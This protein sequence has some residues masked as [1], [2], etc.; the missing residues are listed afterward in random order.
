MARIQQATVW[1]GIGRKGAGAIPVSGLY[2]ILAA[3]ACSPGAGQGTDVGLEPDGGAEE[4]GVEDVRVEPGDVDRDVTEEAVSIPEG[5]NPAA[6]EHDCLMP[7]PSNV[8]LIFDERLP[9]GKRV[10]IGEAGLP[11]TKGNRAINPLSQ[12]TLDGFSHHMP[13]MAQFHQ[14][15]DTS[16]LVFHDQDPGPSLLA[17]HGTIILEVGAGPVAHWAEIDH[18]RPQNPSDR[19]LYLRP[20]D[21]LKNGTR[22]IVALQGL[23]TVDGEPV[24]TPEGFRQIRDGIKGAHPRLDEEIERYEAEIFP[25]LEA[26]GLERANLLL[27]W[28]FTTGTM[29]QIAADLLGMREKTLAY[30]A[31]QRAE[32]TVTAIDEDVNAQIARRVRG[33]MTVPLFMEHPDV[34]ALIFRNEEGQVAQN[35]TVEV[36]FTVVIPRSVMEM[37]PAQRPVRMI[38]YGHGFFGR[39]VEVEQSYMRF[40]TDAVGVVAMAVDWA[41]MSQD[42][43]VK[44]AEYLAQQPEKALRFID[45]VHQGVINQ[46]ALTEAARTTLTELDAL[47]VDGALVYDPDQIYYYGIS[48][49]H[50]F[51]TVVKALSPHLD[52]SVVGVGGASY[53]LMMSRSGSFRNF[54]QV[55]LFVFDHLRDVQKYVAMAQMVF[56]GVDPITYAPL[57]F[58]HPLEGSPPHRRLLMHVGIADTD[59]PNVASH[60]HARAL[61]LELLEPAPRPIALISTVSGPVDG[62]ALVEV[63][64]GI[65]PIPDYYALIPSID[66]ANGVHEAVRRNP[67]VIEQIDRFLRPGGLIEHT[68]EGPCDPE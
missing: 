26:F 37:D 11:R 30:Y 53:S 2:L 60:L 46:L 4:V 31:E 8:F 19:L 12:H 7:F 6:F 21:R 58:E 51:G 14:V 54:L 15:I 28:D 33:T 42:D 18:M 55:M 65:D 48:Q 24:A 63:D 67:R 45:R 20:H 44:V 50:I 36:P 38:Q 32:V 47:K 57:L 40:F 22:Y 39:R 29:D 52:R 43:G 1:K 13:I 64:Y 25:H 61:G 16:G 56:D 35:G 27:A 3:F 17:T 49:G 62:S 66:D 10:A 5:C 23:R 9:S 41:G 34:D 68:C 59:V